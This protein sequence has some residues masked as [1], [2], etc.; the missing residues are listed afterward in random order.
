M[1][2]DQRQPRHRAAAGAEHV[3]RLGAEIVEDR[4]DVVGTR[5]GGGVPVGSSIVL[6]AWPRGS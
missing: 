2:G 4:G 5:L 1:P 6:F 3:G